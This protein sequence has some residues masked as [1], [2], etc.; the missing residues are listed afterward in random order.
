[1][2]LLELPPK[3]VVIGWL[4]REAVPVLSK[5]HGDTASSHEIPHTV[6]AGPLKAGTALSGVRYLL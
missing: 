2:M 4:T 3:Q 6:H 1:M 5:H